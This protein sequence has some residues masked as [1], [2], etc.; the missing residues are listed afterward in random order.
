MFCMLMRKYLTGARIISLRQPELERMLV[1][2]LACRDELGLESR[3]R[4][5]VEMIGR[6]ANV[7]LVGEDGRIIDCMRRRIS[8]GT[9]CAVCF[10]A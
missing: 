10:P 7:I 5:I 3:R 6:S 9:R 4:L 1:I 2:E 8:A